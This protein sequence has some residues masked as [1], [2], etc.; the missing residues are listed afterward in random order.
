MSRDPIAILRLWLGVLFK[1][2][3][4]LW[5]RDVMLYTGG[6]SFFI[7]LAIFPAVAIAMG[8]YSLF[9]NPELAAAQAE[10]LARLA[11][12][13][14]D[15]I[16]REELLRLARAPDEAMSFQS[17]VALLVGGYASHRGFQALL[18]GLSFIHDEERP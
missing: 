9:A 11:P 13:P 2:L 8:L 1:A 12:S 18:A 6:V 14:A 15:G 7:M 5:G 17:G 10:Y 3:T 4:R 16:L